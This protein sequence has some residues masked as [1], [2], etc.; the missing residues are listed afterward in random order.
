M[1]NNSKFKDLKSK[2]PFSGS[3]ILLGLFLL[4]SCGTAPQKET[5]KENQS[6][7]SL[8]D[9]TKKSGPD[10]QDRFLGTIRADVKTSFVTVA[11]DSFESIKKLRNWLKDDEYMHKNTEAKHNNTPRTKEEN[12]NVYL[13][14]LYIFG[15]SR[16]DDND[17]HLILGSGKSIDKDQLYF[18]AEISGLPDSSSEYFSALS[19]IRNQF[20]SYFGDDVQ[21]EYVFVASAKKPPIHLDYICGSLFFDNHHYGGHSAIKGYKVCSA[22]E[23][24]P[25]TAIRFHEKR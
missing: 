15:V 11:A 20:K 25:V 3:G 6:F 4:F 17:F 1:I 24:H 12:H 9:T 23:I 14:D 10:L 16:E 18:S 2:N 8:K 21:K 22:W 5:S 19:A 13:H 7:Y